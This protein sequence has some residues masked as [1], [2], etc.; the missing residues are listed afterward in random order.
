MQTLGG[1]RI[2]LNVDPFLT[3]VDDVKDQIQATCGIPK[4]RQRLVLGEDVLQ[5]SLDHYSLFSLYHCYAG[6]QIV[7]GSVLTVLTMEP[8]P[9]HL[10]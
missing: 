6:M 3:S 10:A 2:A 9:E 7:P 1:T 5:N 8:E 4:D